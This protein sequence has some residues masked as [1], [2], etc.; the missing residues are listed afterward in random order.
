MEIECCTDPLQDH[1]IVVLPLN[2]SDIL[3]TS[4]I[5]QYTAQA[6]GI[7]WT[8]D[9]IGGFAGHRTRIAR[10]KRPASSQLSY[11]PENGGLRSNRTTP[12]TLHCRRISSACMCEYNTLGA[13]EWYC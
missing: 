4:H 6:I 2:Y 5:T 1:F 9:K 12:N 13:H 3:V 8:G 11:K 10:F 7:M